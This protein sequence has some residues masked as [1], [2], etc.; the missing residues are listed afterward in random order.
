MAVANV[1]RKKYLC[2]ASSARRL[3]IMIPNVNV[4]I[5]RSTRPFVVPFSAFLAI[6]RTLVSNVT[7]NNVCV[8]S[9]MISVF[10]IL[11]M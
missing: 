9:E 6:L 5:G 7:W 3:D 8:T 11:M 1:K 10:L 2:N 4:A